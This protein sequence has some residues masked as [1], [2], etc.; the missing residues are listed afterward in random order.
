[1]APTSPLGHEALLTLARKLEGAASDRD[2]DRVESA[3]RRLLDTLI[4][5]IRAEQAGADAA[6]LSP[7]TSHEIATGQRRLVE[8]LLELAVD[9]QGEDLWRC[10]R[11]ARQLL[12]EMTVQVEDERRAGFATATP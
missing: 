8:D 9:V 6:G 7:E 12:A 4:D 2:R 1:M 3:A 10:E 5:H 11:L